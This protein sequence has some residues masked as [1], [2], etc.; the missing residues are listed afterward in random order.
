MQQSRKPAMIAKVDASH[1]WPVAKTPSCRRAAMNA[2]DMLY[3]PRRVACAAPVDGF[4]D[5]G[6][7]CRLKGADRKPS[8]PRVKPKA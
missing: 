1:A 7:H 6:D 5:T 8:E 3:L 2:A 4:D